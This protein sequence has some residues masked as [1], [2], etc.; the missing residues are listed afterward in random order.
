VAALKRAEADGVKE[1]VLTG[2]Q[3]GAYGHDRGG[4]DLAGLLRLALAET[5]IPRIRMSSLQPQEMSPALLGL[6]EDQR[7]CRHFHVPLQSGSDAVLTRMRRRYTTREF[8][9]ALE[10]IRRRLPDAAVTTDV[11]VGFPGETEA[12]F[13]ATRR[14]CEEAGFAAL[15]VFPFSWRPGTLAAK[16]PDQVSAATKRVRVQE[17]LVLGEELHDRFLAPFQGSVAD[18]LWE[19]EARGNGKGVWEGLTSNYIRV[20]TASGQPLENR[21]ASV[22]LERRQGS[23]FWGE[24]QPL[25]KTS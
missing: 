16:M 18:V 3:P 10:S 4:E 12:D 5:S 19:K 13:A 11:L 21:L 24:L 9:A 15:H 8:A 17:M 7:L 6:W 1:V 25:V 20:L 2:T 14:L 23:G 22:R